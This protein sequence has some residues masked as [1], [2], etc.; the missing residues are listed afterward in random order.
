[1]SSTSSHFHLFEKT[2]V[3]DQGGAAGPTAA[4]GRSRRFRVAQTREAGIPLWTFFSSIMS[5]RA[6]RTPATRRGLSSADHTL[7]ME[8]I[9]TND[10]F[11]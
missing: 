6:A 11:T 3:H 5:S 8:E 2:S 1:M 9:E 4:G 7:E 10:G